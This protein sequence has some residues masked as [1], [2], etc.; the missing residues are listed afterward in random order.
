M[1]SFMAQTSE[2]FFKN[3]QG[4]TYCSVFKVRCRFFATARLLYHS[5][6]RLSITFFNF[7]RFFE[8]SKKFSGERGIW[9]LAPVSRPTP[10]AGAPLRPLEYFSEFLFTYDI[11]TALSQCKSYYTKRFFYCQPFF[12]I[13]FYILFLILNMLHFNTFFLYIVV[14]LYI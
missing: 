11:F 8:F 3:F 14:N 9:T 5:F 6:F 2:P 13:I 4:F 10:L 1:F 12:L 7:F